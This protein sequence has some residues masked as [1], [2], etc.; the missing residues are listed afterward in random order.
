VGGDAFAVELRLRYAPAVPGCSAVV[1]PPAPD[2][3]AVAA[4]AGGID[5]DDGS[6]ARIGRIDRGVRLE[7][8]GAVGRLEWLK[9][10]V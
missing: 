1:R 6:P 9:R 2:A 4:L 5:G 8:G 7:H 10:G 3:A